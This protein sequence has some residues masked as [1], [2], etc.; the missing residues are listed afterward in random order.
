MGLRKVLVGLIVTLFIGCA[1]YYIS[2]LNISF[3]SSENLDRTDKELIN[4]SECINKAI[5]LTEQGQY[6]KARDMLK[7]AENASCSAKMYIEQAKAENISVEAYERGKNYLD[8]LIICINDITFV[9]ELTGK[10]ES[11]DAVKYMDNFLFKFGELKGISSDIT[12]K[13]PDIAKRLN[14]EETM[15]TLQSI[16]YDMMDFKDEYGRNKTVLPPPISFEGYSKEFQWKDHLGKKWSFTVKISDRKYEGYKNLSHEVK[17][18]EDYLKFV[19]VGCEDEQIREIAKW[20][21]NTYSD[22]ED[23]ANCILRFIQECIPSVPEEGTEYFKYPV[24]TI[25]EGGDCEDKAILFLSIMKAEE[26]DVAFMLYP[27][28][29]MG[30]VA[31]KGELKMVKNAYYGI[32]I[33]GEEKKYYLCETIEKGFKVGSVPD[34]YKETY[35]FVLVIPS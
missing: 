32:P 3:P 34:E 20:F 31:L 16:E 28:H 14:I 6:D 2:P 10:G 4:S 30:G 26:Y 35:P 24:E 18:D 27:Y 21:N 25:I 9:I 5:N 22:R 1:L 15:V 11:S 12:K 7:E 33:E 19:T 17:V 13:Y 23:E 29:K 8:K